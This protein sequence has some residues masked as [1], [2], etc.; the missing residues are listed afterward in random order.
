MLNASTRTTTRQNFI[1]SEPYPD[2]S[3]E[4]AATNHFDAAAHMAR[5][6]A[7]VNPQIKRIS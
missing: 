7:Y 2:P 6:S 3:L 5:T 1:I 4:R